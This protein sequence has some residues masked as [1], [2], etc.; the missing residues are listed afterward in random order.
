M[1]YADTGA[2]DHFFTSTCQSLVDKYPTLLPVHVTMANG[3]SVRSTHT[4]QLPQLTLPTSVRS[5]H[6]LPHLTN[7][8]LSIGKFCDAGCEAVFAADKVTIS[9]CLHRPILHGTRTPNGLW[10]IPL[11]MPA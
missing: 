6:V 8:L 9:D 1:A 4:T 3:T 11:S 10:T 7:S 5:G 2:T